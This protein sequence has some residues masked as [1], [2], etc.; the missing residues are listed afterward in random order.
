[1][2][3]QPG[4]DPAQ[5]PSGVVISRY[6]ETDRAALLEFRR[7]HY[8]ADAVQADPAYVDW[9]FRDAPGVRE[10]GAP[11]WMARKD[12]RVVGALG[13]IRTSVRIGEEEVP[14]AWA[15]DFAVREDLRGSGI[16]EALSVAARLE[17]AVRL[18]M[19]AAPAAQG[20][21]ARRGYRLVCDVPL[22]VR[23]LQPARW[24]QTHGIP[25]ALALLSAPVLPLLAALDDRALRQARKEGIDLLEIRSFDERADLLFTDLSAR[26]PV[27]CRRDRAWLEWRLERHPF[28][29]R[30]LLHWL[31]QHGR[32][33]GY[34]VLRAG[35]YR[36]AP[37]GVLV[38]YLCAPE[39]IGPLL[40]RCIERFRAT[41][42]ATIFCLHMNPSGARAF[43][44]AGFVRRKS[45]WPF[46]VQPEGASAR[47]ARLLVDPGS[48]FATGAD[49]NVDRDRPA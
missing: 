10:S 24:L 6:A 20:I 39:L 42:A 30:Y 47:A 21:T 49:S 41:R 32:T 16:G 27:L 13:R 38:D 36:G 23:P 11:L 31:V 37:A 5:A 8:G 28:A 25:S 3:E 14:A 12:G 43:R 19:E 9:Q 48:W 45:G 18:V 33:V 15:V 34:A 46:L 26:Y 29:H 4:E 44:A 7:L 1:V 22:F 17:P 2:V 40:A 35:T